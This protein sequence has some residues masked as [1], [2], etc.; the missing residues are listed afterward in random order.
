MTL[1]RIFVVLVVPLFLL[2]AGVNGA[3]LYLWERGEAARGLENQALAAAVT[4][5]AFAAASD[6]LGAALSE[7]GR[8][9]AVRLAAANI[10]GLDGLY[11]A[12][13]GQ[14]P[15]RIAGRGVHASLEGLSLPRKAAALP[16]RAGAA[17]HRV[18][19]ALAPAARGEYVIAQ[20]D[21]EPLFAQVAGLKRL[22]AGLVVATG[23]LGFLLAWVVAGRIRRDLSRNSAMIEAIRAGGAPA[24]AEGLAIRE[25]RDLAQAVRLMQTSVAGR[26]ARNER[27][28][29]A[30]DR[31]REEAT[32]V[33]DYRQSAFPPVSQQTVGR[34]LA[35]RMLGDAPAGSFHALCE[36]DG[37]AALVLGECVGK[38]PAEA[39]ALALSA[40]RFFEHAAL[41][42]DLSASVATGRQAFGIARVAWLE[43]TGCDPAETRVLA[44]L[45]GDGAERA[46]AY[47]AR[48]PGLEPDDLVADLS[49][50]LSVSGVLAVLGEAA[51]G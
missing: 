3:L 2:L 10:T 50:L 6:D 35:I 14:A 13:P 41:D 37:R 40:R 39:L 16:I 31:A 48:A 42:V 18:A 5:A 20:I 32:A 4:T 51:Q 47:A 25:T 7:P 36:R 44:L 43:W 46:A 45:E 1:R 19:T 23:L 33:A 12:A 8:V 26:I 27:E 9:L 21:A 11:L 34:R 15:R 22:I 28:L 17:G 29:A 24:S 49:V 38:S 30:R